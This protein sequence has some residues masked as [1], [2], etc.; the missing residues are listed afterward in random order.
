W[1]SEAQE[2]F[3]AP[4]G[5]AEQHVESCGEDLVITGPWLDAET[6]DTALGQMLGAI[7]TGT[8]GSFT[9]QKVLPRYPYQGLMG[10]VPADAAEQ[11]AGYLARTLDGENRTTF[12]LQ[13]LPLLP[14]EA[15]E[16]FAEMAF[17]HPEFL[18]GDL[19][20]STI[21]VVGPAVGRA[22]YAGRI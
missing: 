21:L 22:G 13:L 16:R 4:L 10:I 19:D 18:P 9:M 6:F 14:G 12:L 2:R 8:V 20:G 3:V 15:R 7:G 17:E 5:S 11:V 1:G